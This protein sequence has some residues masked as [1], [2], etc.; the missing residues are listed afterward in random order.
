MNPILHYLFPPDPTRSWTPDPALR[1]EIDLDR[2][3][4]CGVRLGDPL[5]WL[6]KLGPAESRKLAKKGRICYFSRGLQIEA[7]QGTIKSVQLIWTDAE[8]EGFKPFNGSCLRG[9][10]PLA[11]QGGTPESA[12]LQALGE[13]YWRDDDRG[14]IILFYEFGDVEWQAELSGEGALKRLILAKPPLLADD[15][16]RRAYGIDKP[17]PPQPPA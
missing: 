10:K 3:A 12:V 1:L 2:H 14:E 7:P 17:W 5:G 15:A 11:L 8:R 16:Q 9:G 13:P 4:L 6:R